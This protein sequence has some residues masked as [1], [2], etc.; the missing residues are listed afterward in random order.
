[1]RCHAEFKCLPESG[2]VALKPPN[3]S[4]DEA[5]ALSFGG[6]TALDFFKRGKLQPG[7][8]V[9]VN[10]ASGAVDCAAIQLAQ[11]FGAEV[12]GVCGPANAE[13]VKSLGARR[14]F[15][16]TKEDFT[17]SGQTYDVIMDTAGTAPYFR[18]SRSLKKDGR[19]LLVLSGI[20][21]LLQIPWVA[22]TSRRR[23]VA[24]PASESGENLRLLAELAQAGRLRPVV[25][26]RFT[27]ERIADAHRLVD[28]G[29]KRGNVVV[30]L[31][32]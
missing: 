29:H 9:L 28:S 12:D 25:D 10:G 13:F 17:Q 31:A 27:F 22:L 16:Y 14:V 6:N 19:L 11:H 2:A 4:F 3:L 26:R 32:D 8:K 20:G 7:D 15:D 18:C 23:V 30:T 21:G 5:A 1:M 24:G